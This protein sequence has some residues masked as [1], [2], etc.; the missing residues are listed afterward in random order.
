MARSRPR[1][2]SRNFSTIPSSCGPCRN[3]AKLLKLRVLPATMAPREQPRRVKDMSTE[4]GAEGSATATETTSPDEFSELLKQSFKP[5]TER[6]ASDVENAI[7][8]LVREALADADVIQDEVV[9][10]IQEMIARLDE[11]LSAQV[12]EIMHHPVFQQ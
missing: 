11:K 8:I 10:T 2:S 1:T 7:G 6:A 5:R 12:N 3:G 4:V 9:D